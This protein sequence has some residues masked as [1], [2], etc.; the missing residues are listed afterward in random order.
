MS[1]KQDPRIQILLAHPDKGAVIISGV[2]YDCLN[3]AADKLG[4][5]RNFFYDK[6]LRRKIIVVVPGK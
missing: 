3:D 4:I 6:L 1:K 2:R 5:E